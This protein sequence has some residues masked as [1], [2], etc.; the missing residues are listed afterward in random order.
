[1][2]V[3]VIGSGGREH[4]LAWRISKSPLVERVYSMPG[5]PGMA[6]VG[7]SVAAPPDSSLYVQVAERVGA[8]LT[9]VGPEIPLVAGVVDEFQA[10]GRAILGPA[11]VAAQLEGSKI[12]A[13]KFFQQYRIPTAEFVTVESRGDALKA[14]RRF[15]FP[16]VLKA[17]GLAAGKGVVVVRNQP[18][19]E[20]AIET[21]GDRLVVE[22]FLVGEE[23]SFIVLADGRNVLP[24]PA[25]QDHKAVF[26]GDQGPNTGG[27]GAYSDDRILTSEQAAFVLERMIEPAVN[28]TGFTG[29][30]YAGVML[31]QAGPKLLEFNVRMGDPEAQP[32]MH[33]LKSDLVPVLL[34][35]ARGD[36]TGATLEWSPRPSVCVVLASGGYPGPY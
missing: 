13:K 19:A 28:A 30:L 22:E 33:R 1:M 14:V 11:R 34:A 9:V 16:V 2:K 36:L 6:Q 35:A 15:G 17:D 3:L 32:L 4:A 10:A 26:E 21:L 27:M 25:T 23:A 20:R 18:E 7:E 5:N 12:Y 31:T 24:L 8:D 29:F